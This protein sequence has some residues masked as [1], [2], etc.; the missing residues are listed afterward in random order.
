MA[1]AAEQPSTQTDDSETGKL[2]IRV[3]VVSKHYFVI[4]VS[5]HTLK[6]GTKHV[7]RVRTQELDT[8]G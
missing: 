3:S 1:R 2:S 8:G 7:A 5:S 6:S 4:C